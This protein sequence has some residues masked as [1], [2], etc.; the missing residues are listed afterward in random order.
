MKFGLVVHNMAEEQKRVAKWERLVEDMAI[1]LRD[2]RL[3]VLPSGEAMLVVDIIEALLE[4]KNEVY[5][6][7]TLN[8][9][10]IENLPFDA[11]VELSSVV[12]GY[13]A[14]STHVGALPPS[15][16]AVLNNHVEVQRLTVEA[17]LT[18]DRSLAF[19]ALLQDPQVAAKLK[20]NEVNRLL[21]DLL[22]VH[23]QY[24]PHFFKK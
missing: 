18:G 11:I 5:V 9:G 22:N 21:D 12:G 1:G 23:A 17:A 8:R 7:N 2:L 19:Q 3:D 14:I 4:N 24:L 20:P 15:L 6:V 16:A 13:G 10:A